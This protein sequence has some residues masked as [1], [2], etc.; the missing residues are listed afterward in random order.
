MFRE[1]IV[2][3]FRF[4]RSDSQKIYRLIYEH[5][6]AF[7]IPKMKPLKARRLMMQEYFPDLLLITCADN[8]GRIPVKHD[9]YQ[10][11]LDIYAQFQEILQTKVFLTGADILRRYPDLS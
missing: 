5:L 8:R 4:S 9:E 10:N 7:L 2:P 1:Q 6:R 3:R 11:I